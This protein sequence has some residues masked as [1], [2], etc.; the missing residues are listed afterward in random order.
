MLLD[1]CGFLEQLALRC[2]ARA[3]ARAHHT[4]RLMFHARVQLLL[5]KVHNN[6]TGSGAHCALLWLTGYRYSKDLFALQLN[7]PL[8]DGNPSSLE[9]Q[10]VAEAPC[11]DC[12]NPRR[13]SVHSLSVLTFSIIP[14]WLRYVN[15]AKPLQQCVMK[16]F[17]LSCCDVCLQ[18]VLTSQAVHTLI[19]QCA[20]DVVLVQ[21]PRNRRL[22]LKRYHWPTHQCQTHIC[23]A[24]RP[25]TMEQKA[26]REE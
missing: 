11:W 24:R 21:C 18:L 23:A 16:C 20:R 8:A 14:P 3:R 22:A 9:R 1:L 6:W 5:A 13:S 12:C 15:R 2:D 10:P 17:C 7:V 26:A 25:Y 4:L 19:F